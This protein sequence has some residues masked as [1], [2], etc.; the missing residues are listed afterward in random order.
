MDDLK[1]TLIAPDASE[2]L[3]WSQPCDNHDNFNIHFDDE[4]ASSNWPCPP[5]DGLTYKP[6]NT[7]SFFDGKHSNGIWTMEVEDVYVPEDGGSLASWGLK[8]CGTMSCQRTVTQTS[9]SAV[10][11]L[12]AAIDCANSGDTVRLAGF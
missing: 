2:R 12:F 7:L 10:G 9:G 11:S 5:T 1:F 6:S 4:A 3:I 8:V